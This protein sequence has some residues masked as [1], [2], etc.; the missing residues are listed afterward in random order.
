MSTIHMHKKKGLTKNKQVRPRWGNRLLKG[1]CTA[2]LAV[3]M[4]CA[5]LALS[6]CSKVQVRPV[7]PRLLHNVYFDS[8]LGTFFV[9][10]DNMDV[11]LLNPKGPGQD[12][13][14]SPAF[15]FAAWAVYY[16]KE[17]DF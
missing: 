9:R 10:P 1:V 13:L 12:P 8:K 15:P 5:S 7:M 14:Y 3:A 16:G 2:G 11:I 4:G 17:A 6:S